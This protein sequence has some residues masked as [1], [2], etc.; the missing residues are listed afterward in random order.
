MTQIYYVRH[1]EPNYRNHDDAARELSPRGQADCQLVTDFL[2]DKGI[3]V[4]LSSPYRRAVDTLRPFAESVRLPIHHV[5]DFRERK[6]DS[7]WIDDFDAFSR[8]QWADF[9]FRLD[10]G[11]SL[12]EV[13][14]RNI[15]AL[16]AVL[17]EHAGQRIAIGGHGTAISAILNHY[18]PAFGYAQFDS[19]RRIMPWIVRMDFEGTAFLG[20]EGFV[21]K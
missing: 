20:W 4:I 16:Q 21:L 15:A 6:V 7:E 9:D 8:R 17:T 11:E 5:A 10:G 18:D 3:D 13:Q 1:A 12:R 14:A 19:I 2:L